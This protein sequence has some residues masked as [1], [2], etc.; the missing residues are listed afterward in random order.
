MSS[1]LLVSQNITSQQFQFLQQQTPE[2][3]HPE[4]QRVFEQIAQSAHPMREVNRISER[5]EFEQLEGL[6]ERDFGSER[7]A[8][9]Y[10]RQL[11]GEAQYF[12]ENTNHSLSPS[13]KT[14]VT[15]VL[16]TLQSILET[17][18]NSFGLGDFFRQSGDLY[19]AEHKFH[20]LMTLLS[21]M[22][23]IT[24]TLLPLLGVQ[25]GLPIV[26]GVFLMITVLSMIY[27][28]IA[29]K[30][31]AL[32]E[33]E[34]WSR[35]AMTGQF[36][37]P[38][39][40]DEVVQQI[41][42][43]LIAGRSHPM[44]IGPSGVGKTEAVKAFVNA[45]EAGEF[46]ELKGKRVFY[47]NTANI[48]NQRE[49]FSGGNK[50]LKRI[51]EQIGRHKDDIILIFDE[52][53][54]ACHQ[55]NHVVGEQL[56][57]LLD[58]RFKHVIALTTAQEY[59][60][61]I[62]PNTAFARRFSQI[63]V[64]SMSFSDT[65]VTL[66]Q[67]LLKNA[68]E[69]VLEQRGLDRLIELTSE[70]LQPLSALQA[71]ALCVNRTGTAQIS[72]NVAR[73]E[74]LRA[75]VRALRSVG[76][77]T[78]ITNDNER[79]AQLEQLEQELDDLAD[80]VEQDRERLDKLFKTRQQLFQAKAELY[81]TIVKISSIREEVLSRKNKRLVGEFILLKN[82]LIPALDAHLKQSGE[83]L[84]VKTHIDAALVSAVLEAANEVNQE[85][86]N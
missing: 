11:L 22:T 36:S 55:A 19:E 75:Q 8:L 53:H 40:R 84:G 41:A 72:T 23:M 47:F 37:A 46:P 28:K 64:S 79:L 7:E 15:N 76:A 38:S 17:I 59:E 48:V 70:G 18:L 13:L 3:L 71:L 74:M 49:L 12:L 85:I 24:S 54:V 14:R 60:E 25:A 30:P 83:S 27:P 44:L 29:P 56:K 10:A 21:F 81:K 4:I 68:P 16:E 43:A 80:E 42:D 57:T 50:S 63:E 51:S 62:A 26:G 66:G 69:V 52:M 39:G 1:S 20:K 31:L 78:T 58:E 65:Q 35:R 9:T 82:Y 67:Y 5:L 34:N 32:L 6:F 77:V 61:N 2:Q 73:Q 33:G 45:L 86:I